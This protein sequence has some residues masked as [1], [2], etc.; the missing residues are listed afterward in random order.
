MPVTAIT[1][2]EK[3]SLITIAGA[4]FLGTVG[5]ARRLMEALVSAGVNVILASQGSSEHSITVAVD[6]SDGKK[7][8]DAVSQAFELELAR[9]EET[10]CF[11]VEDC[12]ILA[13]IGEGMKNNDGIAGRFFD[14]LG[15]AKVN[16][17][18][19]AQGSSERNISVVIKRDDLSRALRAVHAGCALSELQ[20]SV[21]VIGT[22]QV[23]TELLKQLHSFQAAVPTDF[24]APAM[25]AVS[26]LSV[27][28]RAVCDLNR[29]V[30]ADGGVPLHAIEKCDK[31][32]AS[33]SDW[34]EIFAQ[35]SQDHGCITEDTDFD[36]MI[37]FFDRADYPHKVII[38]ATE[39][40]SVPDM[41]PKWLKRGIHV[42]SPNKHAG[43]GPEE[44]FKEC[45]H[46]LKHCG[47]WH[48]ESSAGSQLP[49]ISTIRDLFQTGDSIKTVSG[50]LSGTLSS[51]LNSLEQNPSMSFSE[52]VSHAVEMHLTESNC[53]EDLS[54]RD[55][56]RKA[57]IIARELGL[58]LELE[59][60]SIQSLLPSSIN[61]EPKPIES[62]LSEL[63]EHVDANMAE[64]LRSAREN[65][66]RLAYVAEIDVVAG[67]V[68]V[69]LK[70]FT[71]ESMPFLVRENETAVSFV[72][73]R[74]PASTP[75][76]F[77]G[78]GA[79]ANVTA[80]SAFADLLRLCKTL[81]V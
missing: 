72:T 32:L 14:A 65:Q 41:Y 23:G 24:A 30:T 18:A 71:A 48:Y 55:T 5:V 6:A 33:L 16:V 80:S 37:D 45:L 56:A 53:A 8:L 12:S 54:G 21:A 4:S 66:E 60:V 58:E 15:R 47:Q 1:S 68:S 11:S 77:R 28:V 34:D 9:N 10:R 29:M 62:L 79:G 75:L 70:R 67:S 26:T 73:E 27:D 43:S 25:R 74:Y 78:P 50:V 46:Q 52:A 69:G 7:G 35:A 61:T 42:I 38:D 40:D 17:V 44:R 39:S 63:R 59:D 13:V 49:I 57:L 19:I 3:V 22:G 81:R 51:V 64:V 20:V 31:D 76:I 36:K 2:I